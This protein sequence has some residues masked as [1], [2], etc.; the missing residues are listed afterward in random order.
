MQVIL[1]QQMIRFIF[2]L[3]KIY[4][5]AGARTQAEV[6][7][8]NVDGATVGATLPTVGTKSRG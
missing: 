6:D 1:M 3:T 7:A 4:G 5:E 2:A 8:L